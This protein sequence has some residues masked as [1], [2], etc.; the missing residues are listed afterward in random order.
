MQNGK[1]VI[2]LR[3]GVWKLRRT[4][5]A[6]APGADPSDISKFSLW[7]EGLPHSACHWTLCRIW[8]RKPQAPTVQEAQKTQG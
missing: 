4:A 2:S 5:T 8:L 3:M 1:Q 6:P 7:G